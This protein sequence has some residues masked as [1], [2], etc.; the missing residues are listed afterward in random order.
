LNTASSLDIFHV[1]AHN[2]SSGGSQ[3][4]IYLN[5]LIV[6]RLFIPPRTWQTAIFLCLKVS[7]DLFI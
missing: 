6:I 3:K 4:A 7:T 1:A 5:Y 2:N